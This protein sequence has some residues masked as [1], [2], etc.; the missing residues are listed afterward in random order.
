MRR[1]RGNFSS[2]L[3]K[4]A[5]NPVSGVPCSNSRRVSQAA[6]TIAVANIATKST[7]IKVRQRLMIRRARRY[8]RKV[9]QMWAR[10]TTKK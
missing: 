9:K 1:R 2:R 3:G 5:T 4:W 8:W 7:I 10:F 6:S